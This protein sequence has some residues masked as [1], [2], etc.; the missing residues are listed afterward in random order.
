MDRTKL[1]AHARPAHKHQPSARWEVHEAIADGDRVA[2]R[3]TP[4]LSEP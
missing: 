3:Y 1:I 2:A 4:A